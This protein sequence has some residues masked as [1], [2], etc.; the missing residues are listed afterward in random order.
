MAAA[1]APVRFRYSPKTERAPSCVISENMD[2][3]PIRTINV[4]APREIVRD[5][6][7]LFCCS[8]SEDTTASMLVAQG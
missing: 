6:R 7:G 1:D 3:I 8:E 2:T 5:Q 4:N